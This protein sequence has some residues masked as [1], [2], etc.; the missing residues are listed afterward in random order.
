M[1]ESFNWVLNT[2]IPKS[3][4]E[5]MRFMRSDVPE[6]GTTITQL[7]SVF[8][9]DALRY[10]SGEECLPELGVCAMRYRVMRVIVFF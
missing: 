7:I 1:K 2:L 3:K 8:V 5:L 10:L 6:L 4:F 9:R